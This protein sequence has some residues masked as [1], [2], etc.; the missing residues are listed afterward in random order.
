ML[1]WLIR[2]P[3]VLLAYLLAYLLAPIL[4]IFAVERYGPINNA[5]GFGVEPRLPLWLN[6][7]DTLDNSLLGDQSWKASHPRGSYWNRV[8]WLWRNPAY[9]FLWSHLIAYWPPA[10]GVT[11]TTTGDPSIHA[12]D[13][14]KAGWYRIQ[15]SDGSFESTRIR[16][17]GQSQSCL[18]TRIGW[19][20]G[21][22]QPGQPCLYLFSI[23]K[24]PFHPPAD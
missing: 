14:A 24:M 13:D 12:R 8:C 1:R 19:I 15:G 23:R 10:S 7:F 21:D 20:L 2:L 22:V 9:G 4:P 5:S 3:F 11:Y 16:R 6:W 17:L 18:K